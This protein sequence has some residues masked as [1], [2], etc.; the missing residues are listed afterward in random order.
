MSVEMGLR[1][2]NSYRDGSTGNMGS[3]NVDV[4]GHGHGHGAG[5][6]ESDVISD[7]FELANRYESTM[8]LRYWKIAITAESGKINNVK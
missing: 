1:Y 6:C 7:Y 3:G 8:T 2:S 5:P 4:D